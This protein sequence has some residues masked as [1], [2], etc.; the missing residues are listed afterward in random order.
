MPLRHI[1]DFTQTNQRFELVDE[2]IENE[3][4]YDGYDEPYFYYRF[5]NGRPVLNANEEARKS[6]LRREEVDPEK[7]ILSQ[8]KD[9]DH[10]PAVTYL[11]DQYDRIRIYREWSFGRYTPPRQPQKPDQRNDFLKKIAPTSG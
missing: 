4:A 3:S 1:L 11:G 6:G 5:Q 10:Y 2:Q 7:S 8:R 9:P